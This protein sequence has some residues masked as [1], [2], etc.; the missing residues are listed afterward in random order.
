M[1]SSRSRGHRSRQKRRLRPGA[2]APHRM[3]ITYISW[4]ESLQ[5]QRSHGARAGRR[6]RTWCIC[7]RLGSRAADDRASSTPASGWRP[8]RIL[9]RRAA[10][11]GVR[12]DAAGFCRAAG[13][14]VRRGAAARGWCSTRI[15]RH[16]STRDGGACSG[17]SGAVP[18]S[19][20]HARAQRP[21]GR[22][23][24]QDG[25]HA[26]LVPDVPIVVRRRRAVR[27]S[28]GVPS[29]RWSARSTTTS[30]SPRSSRRPDSLPDVRFFVTGNPRH[31]APEL[32]ASL[33]ANVTLTG[34]LSTAAYARPV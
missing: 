18:A 26:T 14:L 31:L 19:G 4:A 1:A 10:R 28:R 5:P 21:P 15:P 12:D 16:S 17:C 32:K 7:R 27:A 6:A 2:R 25:R 11:R 23:R 22:G 34:F 3:T 8:A 9:R 13:V 30:P 24:P 20:D 29:S 33:P